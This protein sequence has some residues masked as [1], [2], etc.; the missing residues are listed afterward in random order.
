MANGSVYYAL[1]R[2]QHFIKMVGS[3]RFDMSAP[4]AVA[5][6]KLNSLSGEED[7]SLDLTETQYIDSTIIGMLA[8][9]GVYFYKNTKRK[10]VIH[11]E[12]TDVKTLLETIGLEKIFDFSSKE[13]MNLELEYKTINAAPENKHKM[14]NRVLDVHRMLLNID[15]KNLKEYGAVVKQ[16]QSTYKKDQS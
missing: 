13:I 8:Q 1:D 4:L 14:K 7:L 6:E 16:L 12:Q 2:H 3:L 11:F 9:L 15:D 10:P 5:I